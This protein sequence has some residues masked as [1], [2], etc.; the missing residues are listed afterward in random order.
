[1]GKLDRLQSLLVAAGIN[2][3]TFNGDGPTLTMSFLAETT[4]AQK[5]TAA[6]ILA[7]FDWSDAAQNAWLLQLERDEAVAIFDGT[8]GAARVSRAMTYIMVDEINSLRGWIT[9]FKA[10]VAAATNLANLQTRVAA[11]ATMP[12]RTNTQAR[13]AVVNKVA[14]DA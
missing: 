7:A 6:A 13:S 9:S 3:V 4:Q 1:M 12:D 10:A 8:D 2:G 11:L 14:A 5:D